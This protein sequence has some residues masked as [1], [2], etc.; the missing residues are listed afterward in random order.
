[1]TKN[2][3]VWIFNEAALGS[4]VDG[5]FS[6]EYHIPCAKLKVD[7]ADLTGS[8]LWLVMKSGSESFLYAMLAPSAIELYEEG[9]Y[10]DDYLLN[11]EVFLSVRFLPRHESRESWRLASFQG[12]EEI[13]ECIHTE[14]SL[15]KELID[16]NHRVSFAPPSRAVLE[17]VPRTTFNDLERAVPDQIMSTLRTVAFGDVSRTRSFPDSI[18]ALGGVTLAILK[19]VYPQLKEAEAVSLIA[20]LDPMAKTMD[21]TEKSRQDVLRVLSS[22]P[23]VVDTFLEEI[24]PDKIS[25][26]S[27]VARTSSYSSKWLDKTND[28]EQAHERILKDLVLRLRNRGF[29]VYKSRSFDV[30][31]EK[32]GARFLWEVKSAN[33][34]NSVA[35]GE[36]GVVQLLRYSMALS[37]DDLSD[38]N[39]LLLLQDS[40]QPAVRHYL[41]KMAERAGI[42]LWF[43]DERKDWPQRVFGTELDVF[44]DL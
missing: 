1:M 23:P 25:P 12:E 36:R 15:F 16:R 44:P 32:L 22:L 43:Y 9:K 41:S 42:E 20:A 31:A 21:T 38:V 35:Q 37:N 13:R 24:D 19:S 39:F 17:S 18:S 5:T 7:P 3:Y 26:R 34:L 29:K 2:D 10:K 30:F 33:G 8:R 40:D 11:S 14:Q 6:L 28:A 4:G 27:F